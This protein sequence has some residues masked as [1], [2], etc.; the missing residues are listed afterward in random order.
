MAK[1]ERASTPNRRLPGFCGAVPVDHGSDSRDSGS[2]TVGPVYSPLYPPEGGPLRGFVCN[3]KGCK[4]VTRTERGIRMH[5]TVVHGIR[6]QGEFVF[7]AIPATTLS[8]DL[9]TNH[10]A[11]W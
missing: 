6:M 9:P 2:G 5:L 3:E 4:A 1:K 7:E 11:A 10:M 8:P